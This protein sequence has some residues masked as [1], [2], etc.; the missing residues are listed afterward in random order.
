MMDEFFDILLG[1]LNNL[2][3]SKGFRDIRK[4]TKSKFLRGVLYVAQ[5]AATILLAV[6]IAAVIF[7]LFQ[8]A[9][10]LLGMFV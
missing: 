4:K 3:F 5:G 2:N 7:L 1:V 9:A 8:L 6:M 10:I